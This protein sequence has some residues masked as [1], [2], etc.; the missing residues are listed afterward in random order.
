[1]KK[2]LSLIISVLIILSTSVFAYASDNTTIVC[3]GDGATYNADNALYNYPFYL[4]SDLGEGYTVY[5]CAKSGATAETYMSSDEYNESLSYNAD[6]VVVMFGADDTANSTDANRFYNDYSSL[7][8]AYTQSEIILMVSPFA[9]DELTEKMITVAKETGLALIDLRKAVSEKN[10]YDTYYVN[11]SGAKQISGSLKEF[12]DVKAYGLKLDIDVI[13]KLD[14]S[15]NNS[16]LTVTNTFVE[17]ETVDGKEIDY[18]YFNREGSSTTDVFSFFN[19]NATAVISDVGSFSAEMWAKIT[20]SDENDRLLFAVAPKNLTSFANASFY[21]SVNG[22]NMTVS[23]GG[24]SSV[25][26]ITSYADKW[27][28]WVIERSYDADNG[29][30]NIDLYA[31]TQ[32]VGETITFSQTK[33]DESE[34]KVYFGGMGTSR[35]NCLDSIFRG[36]LAEARIYD[37]VLS[38]DN[39]TELYN[40]SVSNFVASEDEEEDPEEPPVD[41]DVPPV[42]PEEPEKKKGL[43][44]ELEIPNDTN[45]EFKDNTDETVTV[46][47]NGSTTVETYNGV[48]GSFNYASFDNAS[49]NSAGWLMV[50]TKNILTS[51]ELTIEIWTR[52]ENLSLYWGNMFAL[53]NDTNPNNASFRIGCWENKLA[54]VAQT[55]DSSTLGDWRADGAPYIGKWTHIVFQRSYDKENKLVTYIAY[56]NGNQFTTQIATYTERP[57]EYAG[58]TLLGIGGLTSNV[59]HA[60][61]GDVS[62]FRAYNKLLSEDEIKASYKKD[63]ERHTDFIFNHNSTSAPARDTESI[64]M[65]MS[66]GFSA[67]DALKGP[68]IVTEND[69][70]VNAQVNATDE[71]EFILTFNRYIKYGASFRVYSEYLDAYNY[72]TFDKGVIS[73]NLTLY[74][75]NIEEIESLGGQRKLIANVKIENS[76][77]SDK[78][79][80]Y[81][82]LAKKSDGVVSHYVTEELTVS[83]SKNISVN[84]SDT[85]DVEKVILYVWEM[86]DTKL[87]PIYNVPIIID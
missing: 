32:K 2:Y 50:D 48:G 37:S 20:N 28:H 8:N 12:F 43:V 87:I 69:N 79:V 31:D 64:T 22:N 33:A 16:G 68:I 86:D 49:K 58:T 84:F 9:S 73:A 82:L 67:L 80:K 3:V 6:I 7:V 41:P 34:M 1:M 40:K 75:E 36:Y 15:G 71:S 52:P 17:S 24:E 60:Y 81:S 27:V 4:E 18:V 72:L 85:Q 57:V 23:S 70:K 66:T 30:V 83:D 59:S 61:K 46:T 51:D 63:L 55:T 38:S 54:F 47:K 11:A 10:K 53:S 13:N 39:I 25:I 65:K 35:K 14:K 5:N 29:N 42:D 45:G 56:I 26:D 44:F 76:G 19:A 74:D 62:E 21:V 77:S 78:K